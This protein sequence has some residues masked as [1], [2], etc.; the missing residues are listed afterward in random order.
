MNWLILLNREMSLNFN[1]NV[2]HQ[3]NN[4]EFS[5]EKVRLSSLYYNSIPNA[6]LIISNIVGSIAICWQFREKIRIRWNNFHLFLF[7][8]PQTFENYADIIIL[9]A[10]QKIW[11]D[12]SS[13]HWNIINC[14]INESLIL[15]IKIISVLVGRIYYSFRYVGV[16]VHFKCH[17]HIK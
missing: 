13:S 3:S 12:N 1:T 6:I 5:A 10:C 17:H 15:Q 11:L 9:A 8:Q 4:S 7:I 2:S 16:C 14:G